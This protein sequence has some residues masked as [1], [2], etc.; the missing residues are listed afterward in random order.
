M[1]GSVKKVSNSFKNVAKNPLDPKAYA[2]MG[3]TTV[4]GGM[5]DTGGLSNLLMGKKAK[6]TKDSYVPLDAT[7][8]RALGQYNSLLGQK[9]DQ[10]AKNA[11]AGQEN[12]IRANAQDAERKASQLVAQRGLGN[13]S[14]GLN[15][16]INTTRNMGDQL[17]A[18]RAKLPGLQYDMKV[19]NLN[20]ATNGIQNIL[21]NRIFKQGTGSTGRQGGLL[22][23]IG[24][25]LGAAFGGAA[26]AQVGMGMGQAAT[27]MG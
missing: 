16:M 27:Q 5:M 13:S 10:M 23:L 8:T 3:L 1:G 4:T 22:P 7:Q 20:T 21:T 14:V 18:A 26:G 12:Q 2:D 9:T 15:A 24:G 19:N 11:I 6:G 25:G 17:G